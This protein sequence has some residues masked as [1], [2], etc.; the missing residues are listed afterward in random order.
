MKKLAMI[1]LLAGLVAFVCTGCASYI[2]AG[3]LYTGAQGA[4]AAG[5]RLLLRRLQLEPADL[6]HLYLAGAFGNYVDRRSAH[7][8]GLLPVPVERVIPIGNAALLGAKLATFEDG[9]E[10]QTLHDRIEHVPLHVDP[11]FQDVFADEMLFPEQGQG[12]KDGA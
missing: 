9:C 8:I 3:G 1:A 7:R 6:E 11:G 4:I 2:P 12:G 5:L 10:F